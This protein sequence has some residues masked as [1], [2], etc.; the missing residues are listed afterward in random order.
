MDAYELLIVIG[1]HGIG[2]KVIKHGKQLGV[3]GCTVFMGKGITRQRSLMK[4]LDLD[5]FKREIALLVMSEADE[6]TI[7]V[8]LNKKI[9]F[10][11]RGRIAITIPLRQVMGS[12]LHHSEVSDK[13]VKN[14]MYNAIF[15]IVDKGQ[16]EAVIEAARKAGSQGATIINAR[17]SG[18]H[19][20]NKLFNM[21]I[22][23]EKEVVLV[24]EEYSKV[25]G[26]V[27][28]IRKDL[29]IDEPGKGIIFILD[30]KKSFGL[31]RDIEYKA[32]QDK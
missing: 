21:D 10:E 29:D 23:P 22:S 18:I 1:S 11:K 7:M 28:S 31:F 20:T 24:I 19:E 14:P 27:K 17:G 26:I 12:Q 30:I 5:E 4:Y 13:G 32:E 8:E 25:D 16:G 2:K 9:S 15:T 6:D 3:K